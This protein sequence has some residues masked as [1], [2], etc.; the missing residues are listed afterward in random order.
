MRLIRGTGAGIPAAAL[1]LFLTGC[2]APHLQKA[3]GKVL[4]DGVPVKGGT[5]M[6]YPTTKG[7]PATGSIAGDG[8]FTLS[9]AQPD[10]GLPPGDYKVVIVA[11]IWKVSKVKSKAQLDD[12]ALMK[13]A[14]IEGEPSLYAGGELVHV[15]PTAYNTIESTPLTQTV[16]RSSDPQH[17]VFDI[18]SKKK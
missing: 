14:G 17:Y 10:D 13:K 4:V 8:S 15:V 9:F 16:A 18:P 11:D 7:R 12:E 1:A 6:F 3:G 2:S 5:I